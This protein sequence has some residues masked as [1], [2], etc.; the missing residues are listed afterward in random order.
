MRQGSPYL[1]RSLSTRAQE[2]LREEKEA[3]PQGRVPGSQ[4]PA[5]L[6]TRWD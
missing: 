6:L 5:G 1:P 4:K 3:T 2:N